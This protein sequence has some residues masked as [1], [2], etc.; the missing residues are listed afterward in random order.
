MGRVITIT[1]G[2]GGV[3][4]TTS[5]AN[6]AT[7]L[8]SLGHRVVCID[9]DIGL[10]NLDLIMGL[11]DHVVYNVVDVIEERATIA[12][13]L[14][15]H[16]TIPDLFLLP[17]SQSRDK[18]A[19]D[20]LQMMILCNK[21]KNDFDFVL[22]DSPAGI[23]HGFRVSLAPADQVIIVTTPEVAALR[24][25]DRVVGILD[26]KDRFSRS[27]VINRYRHKMVRQG[28]MLTPSEVLEILSCQLIGIIPEDEEV[29][30]AAYDGQLV[31]LNHRSQAGR[32]YL[33]TAKRLLGEEIPF[34]K[35]ESSVSLIDRLMGR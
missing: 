11:E 6:L 35:M 21:L 25:A 23:E 13:A 9:T 28:K 3:G 16:K 34:Q 30:N 29:I 18:S 10:R 20:E 2:K 31:V 24:D 14:I 17:A 12:Q 26:R 4:K 22:I 7:A 27:L 1:S 15:R 8:T 32:E 33:K 5:T 19:I